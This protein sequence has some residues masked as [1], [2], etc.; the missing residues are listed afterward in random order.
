MI[1]RPPRST[2]FPYTTLFRSR[3]VGPLALDV[4]ASDRNDVLSVGNVALQV[5][6]HLAL[7]HDH[8]IVVA[9]RGLEEPL[10]IGRRRGRDDLETRDMG[11]PALPRLRV[12]RG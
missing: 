10:G 2:L 12:L 6:Q 8:R 7:E 5:V 1:R 3:D 11:E 9:D 4:C